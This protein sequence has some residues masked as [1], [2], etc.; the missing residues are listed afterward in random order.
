MCLWSH[1]CACWRPSQ[2]RAEAAAGT[3][4]IKSQTCMVSTYRF[5]DECVPWWRHQME[6][7]SRYW[8]FVR[9]I[10]RSLVNSPL[11][12]QWRGALMFS[13]ISTSINGWVNTR[14]A[15]DL[16]PHRAHYD[17]IV[18]QYHINSAHVL[19]YCVYIN[20]SGDLCDL[21]VHITQGW[22]TG[23]KNGS[24]DGLVHW[25]YVFLAL[26]HRYDCS[27]AS[28]LILTD[29]GDIYQYETRTKHNQAVTVCITIMYLRVYEQI[30]I[31]LYNY[32]R[33][34]YL[35][36]IIFTNTQASLTWSHAR[37]LRNSQEIKKWQIISIPE[38]WINIRMMTR[39]G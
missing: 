22:S 31:G 21:F 38:V 6:T 5:S 13:L 19:S 25:S 33:I 29:M 14:E 35:P 23:N 27:C 30:V 20:S 39:K 28:E 32:V 17:V 16:R 7:F 36:I 8:P 34:A 24:I 2:L 10:Q 18:M 15:G 37:T 1:Q 11:K 4:T 12:G 9:G 3:V 26:T